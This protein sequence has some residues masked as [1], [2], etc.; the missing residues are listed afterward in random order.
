MGEPEEYCGNDEEVY[1]GDRTSYK[2]AGTF[3]DMASSGMCTWGSCGVGDVKAWFKATASY[4]ESD[5]KPHFTRYKDRI[6]RMQVV[7]DGE[8]EQIIA[9]VNDFL[10][11]WKT[12]SYDY[13]H[14]GGGMVGNTWG[15]EYDW[16]GTFGREPNPEG[17]DTFEFVFENDMWLLS[18]EIVNY[19]DKAACFRDD[20]NRTVPEGMLQ[21]RPGIGVIPVGK[22]KGENGGSG[23]GMNVQTL[24]LSFGGYLLVKALMD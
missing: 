18:K 24:A 22:P 11:E 14:G 3:S 15:E 8:Q 10:A 16:G 19:Y 20:F 9:A 2:T 17:P 5:L 1:A 7:P 21:E 4:I 12:Y 6:A 13:R 23:F